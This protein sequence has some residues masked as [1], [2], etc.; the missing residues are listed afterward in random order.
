MTEPHHEHM[1]GNVA[2]L[3]WRDQYR[4]CR[5]RCVEWLA[6]KGCPVC[7]IRAKEQP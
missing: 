7:E 6:T 3:Y 1:T 4:D 5:A 2:A